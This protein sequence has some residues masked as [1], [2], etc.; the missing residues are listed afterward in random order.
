MVIKKVFLNKKVIVLKD[1]RIVVLKGVVLFGYELKIMLSWVC[2][3][4]Y[5]V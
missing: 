3:N 5:G 4:I 1:V 2:R